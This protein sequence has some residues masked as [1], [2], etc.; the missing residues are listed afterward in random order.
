MCNEYNIFIYLC[1]RT[2]SAKRHTFHSNRFLGWPANIHNAYILVLFQLSLCLLSILNMKF[3]ESMCAIGL[4][5]GSFVA[6]NAATH[7]RSP[8]CPLGNPDRPHVA[9]GNVLAIRNL[10]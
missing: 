1:T 7:Q 3:D 2:K 4:I 8:C 5:C 9:L 6:I 10:G